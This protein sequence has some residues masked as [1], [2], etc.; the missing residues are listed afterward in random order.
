VRFTGRVE[1]GVIQIR[2]LA[3]I[4][5]PTGKLLTWLDYL[6]GDP[7]NMPC[8]ISAM[9]PLI[10]K[11]IGDSNGSV[12]NRHGRQVLILSIVVALISWLFFPLFDKL[13]SHNEIGYVDATAT[14]FLSSTPTIPPTKW[15]IR[16]ATTPSSTSSSSSITIEIA[17]KCPSSFLST[18]E[19]GTYAYVSTAPPL[20]NR[21]RTG[22]GRANSYLGQIQ[23]GAGLKVLDGPL[24]FDG[25]TWWLVESKEIR[26]RGWTAVGSG[27]E[28]WVI[29][30]PNPKIPC[31]ESSVSPQIVPATPTLI[32]REGNLSKDNTCKSDRLAIGM[33]ALVDQDSLLVIRSEPYTGSVIGYSGPLSVVKIV[34]GPV[35]AVGGVWFNVNVAIQNISGWSTE[36]NL[37]ECSEK[38]V[39]D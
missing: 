25:I 7:G 31:E 27:S 19:P 1:Q 34:D 3:E 33:F 26:L 15:W 11:I 22:A 4:F 36:S 28:Q 37:I 8:K 20:P 6:G 14:I 18:I 35:C 17:S 5:A 39:C 12:K 13:K 23:P 30:C 32:A 10:G 29:P 9:K 24:C 2:A 38:G 21:V 16:E